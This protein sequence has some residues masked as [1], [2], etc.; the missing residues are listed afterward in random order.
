MKRRLINLLIKELEHLIDNLKADNSNITEEE[1][2]DI[3]SVIAH[4]ALSKE[5]ACAYLNMSRA[6]FDNHIRDGLLPKGRKRRGKTALVW[7][8]DELVK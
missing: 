8:K 4:E 3:L 2:I 1:A 7:Y 6:T 5:E